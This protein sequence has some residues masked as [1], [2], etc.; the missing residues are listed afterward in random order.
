MKKQ[1]E[2]LSTWS[3][4]GFHEEGLDAVQ[5]GWGTHETCKPSDSISSL[6]DAVG[7]QPG[8]QIY[9]PY[10]GAEML[11]KSYVPG[12]GEIQGLNIP[13]SEAATLASYLTLKCPPNEPP[14][15]QSCSSSSGSS[16]DHDED[17]DD[18]DGYDDG[19]DGEEDCNGNLHQSSNTTSI[20]TN[21]FYR[22]TVHYV[23]DPPT[24]A[25]ESWK[26]VFES[27]KNPETGTLDIQSQT[28]VLR[29]QEISHGEDAVGVLLL[30]E[31][32]PLN[33][34]T[35]HATTLGTNSVEGRLSPSCSFE[36]F[37]D[38]I[39]IQR[40]SKTQQSKPKRRP[41]C[42]WAGTILDIETTR[43]QLGPLPAPTTVQ[44]VASLLGVLAYIT[45]KPG[46]TDKRG[47]L[48]PEDLPSDMVL[49]VA[50]PWLGKV[51]FEKVEWE[52]AP[53]GLQ[54]MDM[55]VG[56]KDESKVG[57]HSVNSVKSS[58]IS[59]GM[60]FIGKRR[61]EVK[62]GEEVFKVGG[63]GWMRELEG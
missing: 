24:C 22:P 45:S 30:F 15:P 23:Y 19:H 35:R 47:V 54:F 20:A 41:F 12:Q 48:W 63:S 9:L 13:H 58:G 61:R 14:S 50:G 29:G 42:Y 5:I 25:K 36:P 1:G 38:I 18:D 32:T 55:M 46:V 62:L 52:G 34:I 17:D 33:F 37:N 44:V 11:M 10:R 3:P 31:E 60:G 8:P 56:M 4:A 16:S 28:R 59:D 49:K 43:A 40:R 53:L 2:F 7:G 6:A 39:E 26:E 51:V 27:Y 57:A 21:V